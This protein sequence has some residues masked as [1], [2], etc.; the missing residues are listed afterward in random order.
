MNEEREVEKWLQS[1]DEFAAGFVEKW[2][3]THPQQ[4]RKLLGRVSIPPTQSSN[5]L[6]IEDGTNL[7]QHCISTP[8][9]HSKRRKKSATE[10]RQLNHQELFMELLADVVSPDFDV[11]GLSHK[12]L[13]NVL[14]LTNADR[15]SL[16]LVE[17]PSDKPVLVSR[18]FD[19]TEHSTVEEAIHEEADSIKIPVGVGI[20]GH[21]A[22]T[23]ET[24]NLQ[25][26]Y[27][28]PRFNRKVDQHTGYLTKSILCMPIKAPDGQ[29][30]GVAQVINKNKGKEVFTSDDEQ[31]FQRFLTFCAIGLINAQLLDQS[32]AVSRR[33]QVLL[34]LARGLFEDT[35]STEVM[36]RKVMLES[37]ELIP[38]EHCT[39]L[40]LDQTEKTEVKFSRAFQVDHQKV[41]VQSQTS[42]KSFDASTAMD[43]DIAEQVARTGQP[44]NVNDSD[45]TG[46][47]LLI[48]TNAR[49]VLCVPITNRDNHTIGIVMLTHK[50]NG[51]PF[52]HS[53][54][55]L[56]EVFATFCG[57]GIHNVM[58]YEAILK[59][60]A[61][62]KVAVE[63]LSYHA[64]GSVE[65]TQRLMKMPVPKSRDYSLT[66]LT[67]DDLVLSEDQTIL[68]TVRM[69]MDCGLMDKFNIES[70]LLYRWL[71]S[72][73]KNYRP[74][75]YHNWRHA[76]NVAQTM[77]AMFT[78]GKLS[79]KMSRMECL[80]LLIGCLC[81]DLDH[82]GTNNAFQL[83]SDSPLAQL[84]S[85]S[86]MEHHHF[87]HCIMILNSEGNQILN[88]LNTAQYNEVIS[89]LESAIL[90]TDLALYFRKKGQF[91]ELVKEK[92]FNWTNNS[93]R[94]LLRAMMMTACDVSAITK[95]WEVQ[96]R[97]AELV[98]GEFFE[99]GDRER[100]D[101]HMEPIA[102]MDR[103]K[104][105]DLPKMQVGFIDAICLPLYQV[106]ADLLDDLSPLLHGVTS[107][108]EHWQILADNPCDSLSASSFSEV[109]PSEISPTH[110]TLATETAEVDATRSQS[111]TSNG[112]ITAWTSN[113]AGGS[114]E[115][116]KA[117]QHSGDSCGTHAEVVGKRK[118]LKCAVC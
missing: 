107:N 76:F 116:Q 85:S 65:D 31:E 36:V 33:L 61:R 104:K 30:I 59:A 106:L 21:T 2:L 40:L 93:H 78:E 11:N 108:R 24:I 39:V 41:L 103:Q 43:L 79:A 28:D 6:K 22:K 91:L 109:E 37:Q 71:L 98:A 113:S 77:F 72:V 114:A 4:A 9:L 117:Q 16:F 60:N 35:T 58:T 12:I 1:H 112:P 75:T 57:L 63:V 38:C 32:F 102:M 55:D 27:E 14:L 56:F 110:T 73:K 84:Y 87:D 105:N 111:S 81:H 19:V 46:T 29:V 92:K 26:A 97:T 67:F 15:S 88:A 82:R 8:N 25:D 20:A 7:L 13:V 23:G 101:L 70:K 42:L 90:S 86:T 89:M 49:S 18:L 64:S 48:D 54:Q 10:L 5:L 80:S 68:C 118:K 115:I 52:N 94:D 74:V 53:D 50:L 100:N 95:P 3:Y 45:S 96:K 17:G 34:Q 51:L 99:Q 47:K 66:S 69:F 44:M 62:Q 83:K